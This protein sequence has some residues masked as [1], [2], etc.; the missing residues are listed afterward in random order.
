MAFRTFEK[1]RID[2]DSNATPPKS[3]LSRLTHLEKPQNGS[4]FLR[5][6]LSNVPSQDYL[7]V[8]ALPEE[9]ELADREDNNGVQE[10]DFAGMGSSLG[11]AS[12][13]SSLEASLPNRV[14][15]ISFDSQVTLE[16]GH[17]HMMNSPLPR[18]ESWTAINNEDLISA[19]QQNSEH[20]RGHSDTETSRYDS[21]TG[22]PLDRRR[23]RKRF[24]YKQGELGHPI[25]QSTIDGLAK[26]PYLGVHDKMA[27][28]TSATTASTIQEEIQTPLNDYLPGPDVTSPLEFSPGTT[29][30]VW[31]PTPSDS[32]SRRMHSTPAGSSLGSARGRRSSSR[33]SIASANSP[34]ANYLNSWFNRTTPKAPEE[35]D[36]GQEIGDHS[37]YIIGKQIGQGGFSTVKEAVTI[38]SGQ[39]VTCAVKIVRKQLPGV[40]ETENERIQLALEQELKLWSTLNYKYILPLIEA[41]TT[42]FATYC[43]MQLNKGGTLH[44]LMHT[45][46][47]TL[48]EPGLEP[49]LAKR[50][51]YQLGCAI[52]YLHEDMRIVHRDIKLENCLLNMSDPR[53][54]VDGGNVL[55]CD[56]GMA[57]YVRNEF[58][59][60]PS[61]PPMA[62]IEHE[63][64]GSAHAGRPS[65]DGGGAG[66]N[67][68]PG[69]SS[70]NVM[71]TLNYAAPEVVN[72]TTTL[73]STAADMW[74]YGVCMFLLITGGYP[75]HHG[76]QPRLVMMITRG[77]WDQ[78]VL[79]DSPA[80]RRD[81]AM[82][83]NLVRG[84]LEPDPDARYAVRQALDEDWFVGCKDVYDADEPLGGWDS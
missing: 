80:V 73:F 61:P 6:D 20:H 71:G 43:I 1:L 54:S 29:S 55:L 82:V 81:G 18:A 63:L 23:E 33:R 70:T 14:T 17:R 26:D 27:S 75:F 66:H 16:G 69:A 19:Y 77:E 50:Y 7:L 60:S 44:E 59:S 34:A 48:A 57:D 2:P 31:P 3:G 79:L 39:K 84:C 51:I 64:N 62:S 65:G 46:K 68:G 8:E 24:Y 25:L 49:Y 83:A 74:S 36:E 40:D 42:P 47:T 45:R 15:S 52:R 56:F 32:Q 13:L 28:L 22:E 76:F 72:A 53:A 58:R 37:Q 38:K 11:T 12:G 21:E 9:G 78:S 35:D 67:I 41:H 10:R 4:L 30:V 5:N